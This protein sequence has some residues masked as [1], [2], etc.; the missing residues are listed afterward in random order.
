MK[1]EVIDL[2][3]KKTIEIYSIPDLSMLDFQEWKEESKVEIHLNCLLN[4]VRD[5]NSKDPE[6]QDLIS[7][8][9]KVDFYLPDPLMKDILN[10]FAKSQIDPGESPDRSADKLSEVIDRASMPELKSSTILIAVVTEILQNHL[11]HSDYKVKIS[12]E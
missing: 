6:T 12:D 2:L 9:K 7:N 3:T 10:Q 1:V 8:S 11:P 5:L 4:A